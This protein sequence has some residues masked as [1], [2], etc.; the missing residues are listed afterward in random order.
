MGEYVT[1]NSFEELHEIIKEKIPH[2]CLNC[3]YG[4]S[5]GEPSRFVFCRESIVMIDLTMGQGCPDWKEQEK[6]EEE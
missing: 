1:V 5:S 2:N 6:K 3:E 4:G